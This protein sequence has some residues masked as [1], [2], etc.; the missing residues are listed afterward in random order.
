MLYPTPSPKALKV[1]GKPSIE[2]LKEYAMCK[3]EDE[4][5]AFIIR[6][7]KINGAKLIKKERVK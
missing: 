2:D 5:V 6:D 1:G 7:C 4:L 3:T